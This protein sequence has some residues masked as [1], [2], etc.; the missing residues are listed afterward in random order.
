[1]ADSV[2]SRARAHEG[3]K[4][5]LRE[6]EGREVKSARANPGDLAMNR[7]GRKA[8]NVPTNR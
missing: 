4:L 8:P 2:T 1:M 6:G 5:G 7:P 3:K